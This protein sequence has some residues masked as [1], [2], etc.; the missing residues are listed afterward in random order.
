[1]Y[2]TYI[3]R[4]KPNRTQTKLLDKTISCVQ[5]FDDIYFAQIKDTKIK[6]HRE[7]LN[8]A[9]NT[10]KDL[11]SIDDNILFCEI[12]ILKDVKNKKNFFSKFQFKTNLCKYASSIDEVIFNDSINI[13]SIGTIKLFNKRDYDQVEQ[14]K[15]I[16]VY[17][18][19]DDKYFVNILFKKKGNKITKE[20]DPNNSIGLDYSSPNFYVDSNGETPDKP[21]IIKKYDKQIMKL[22]SK[23]KESEDDEKLH[24][25]F[26][27]E[28][29]NLYN[30][31]KN[32]RK[33]FIHKTSTK[34]ANQYDYVFVENID[35]AKIATHRNLGKATNDNAYGK[36]LKVLDYKMNDRGKKLIRIDKFY[37]S[38][39]ICNNCGYTYQD[40]TLKQRKWICPEC[41]VLLD[42]DINAAINIRNR[43]IQLVNKRTAGQSARYFA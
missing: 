30:D 7:M 40:L 6:S 3:L 8:I 26:S 16:I 28:Y 17:R 38:S 24:H 37:P 31:I 27:I 43:G 25:K 14:F 19:I 11:K 34:L 41:G 10:D 18:T 13:P 5:K 42:R 21:V 20:L 4:L 33:D 15:S 12:D 1:M 36:F 9:R 32:E 39:Q 35:L 22:Q 23:L 2:R 29:A